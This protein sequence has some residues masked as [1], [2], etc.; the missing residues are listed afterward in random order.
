M[1]ACEES[2]KEEIIEAAEL[3]SEREDGSP[4]RPGDDEDV[5]QRRSAG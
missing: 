5:T 4:P 3:D 1:F 2:T